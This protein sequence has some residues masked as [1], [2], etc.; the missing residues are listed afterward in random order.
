MIDLL[1]FCLHFLFLDQAGVE[2]LLQPLNDLVFALVRHHV[3]NGLTGVRAKA[4]LDLTVEE[5]VS[6]FTVFVFDSGAGDLKGS[7]D[8]L[9][10]TGKNF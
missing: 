6:D 5:L 2:A 3:A 4:Y 1:Q 7:S 9:S 10:D 8:F